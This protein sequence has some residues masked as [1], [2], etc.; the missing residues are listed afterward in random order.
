M[1]SP[2]LDDLSPFIYGTTRLG[3]ASLPLA[4]RVRTAR[5]A[6]DVGIYFHTS[7]QY[8]DAFS[9][10][11][12]AFDEDPA[13]VPPV[14]FKIGWSS[15]DEIRGQIKLNTEPLGLSKMA[16]GQLCLGGPMAEEFQTGGPCYDGFRKMQDE[17][18][19]E[20]FVVEVWPWNSEIVLDALRGGWPD[21]IISG[22][23]FY[24]NPLQ[25]FV[26][27]ELFD[28][29][30]EQNQSIVAMRTVAGG[31]V[32]RTRDN[33]KAPDYLRKRAAQVAPLFER[34]GC[35]T[36]PEFCLRYVFGIPQ[37]R[38]SVGS[39]SRIE[40]LNEFLQAAQSIAPLP[41]DIQSEMLQLQR[42][43]ADEHDRFAEPWSM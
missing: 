35:A 4:D 26:S 8:G 11:R 21:G 1:A 36:W 14:I 42:T 22:Y 32:L 12:T 23:I 2:S 9:P 5:A 6:M 41:S 3:D 38:A 15:L 33:E 10:L 28:L 37:V 24:L 40:N 27:N 20:R 13:H 39:T 7:H 34:S 16:I 29:L 17:G 19:V 31:N 25:R 43:W 30:Q 18:L